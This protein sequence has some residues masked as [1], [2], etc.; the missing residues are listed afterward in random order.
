MS[1]SPASGRR[2]LFNTL[3]TLAALG[4]TGSQGSVAH[5]IVVDPCTYFNPHPLDLI[6]KEPI[7]VFAPDTNGRYYRLPWFDMWTHPVSGT[8]GIQA[9]NLISAP[10]WSGMIPAGSAA[11]SQT[12]TT[13]TPHIRYSTHRPTIRSRRSASDVGSSRL[14]PRGRSGSRR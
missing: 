6:T 1:V 9:R 7:I 8:T 14:D 4:A 5:A 2:T 3:I 10:G 11:P 12:A 13:T